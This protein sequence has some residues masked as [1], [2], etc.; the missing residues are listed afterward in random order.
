MAIQCRD[1][2]SGNS[3]YKL[4]ERVATLSREWQLKWQLKVESGNSK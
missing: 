3:K 1:V 2:E 4:N